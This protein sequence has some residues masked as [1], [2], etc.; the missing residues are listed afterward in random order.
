MVFISGTKF[1]HGT[2][3]QRKLVF[4]DYVAETGCYCLTLL[5]KAGLKIF[6]KDGK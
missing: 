6:L 3:I 5:N 4:C 1:I 2:K